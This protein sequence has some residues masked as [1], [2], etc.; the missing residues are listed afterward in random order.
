LRFVIL[1]LRFIGDYLLLFVLKDF[2][3]EH[4]FFSHRSLRRTL[5]L[6]CLMQQELEPHIF[7][8]CKFNLAIYL[9]KYSFS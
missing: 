2:F 1:D 3:S 9:F 7:V 4:Y 5:V 8:G 6:H